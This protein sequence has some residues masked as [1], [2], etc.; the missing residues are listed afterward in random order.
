[1]LIALKLPSVKLARRLIAQSFA[2]IEQLAKLNGKEVAMTKEA[3]FKLYNVTD[4]LY[5]DKQKL[6]RTLVLVSSNLIKSKKHVEIAF[7]C[8]AIWQ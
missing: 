4:L 1:M 5:K 7:R 8:A 6:R 3:F 2:Y